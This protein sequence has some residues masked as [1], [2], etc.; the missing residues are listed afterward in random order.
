VAPVN[1]N[2]PFHR[3][4][5]EFGETLRRVVK[6]NPPQVR[7]P[8]A[9]IAVS[10]FGQIGAFGKVF[11]VFRDDE[12]LMA[13]FDDKGSLSSEPQF[14]RAFSVLGCRLDTRC[15]HTSSPQ[16]HCERHRTFTEGPAL[17]QDRLR[18]GDQERV[19]RSGGADLVTKSICR[20]NANMD[21]PRIAF[22]RLRR[23]SVW[24]PSP[25]SYLPSATLAK[26]GR[27][28]LTF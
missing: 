18:K 13:R 25:A 6:S 20:E 27:L 3:N 9:L 23:R 19:L 14:L 10:G 22:C 4:K 28:S 1:V 5:R 24:A 8:K 17:P 2:I 16:G 15:R 12:E 11:V 26:I 21:L 7:P